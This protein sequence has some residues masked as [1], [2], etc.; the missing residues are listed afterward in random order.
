MLRIAVIS[1]LLANLLLLGFQGSKPAV[2]PETIAKHTVVEDPGIPTIHLYSEMVQDQDLMSGSRRC[3]SLGPFHSVEDKNETRALLEEVSANIS[4]RETRALVEK[5]YWVFMPPYE[6]LLKANQMLLSLQ[7]LGLK[8]VA[9][10]YNGDWT[11]AVSL[12]Y[13]LRQENAL[14][15]KEGLE[16]RGFAPKMRV[17]RQSESRYWLDVEQSPGSGLITM[18]MQDRPNDFMQ[19]SLPCPDQDPFEITAGASEILA[20]ETQQPQTQLPEEEIQPAV[21]ENIEPPTEETIEPQPEGNIEPPAEE[22]IEPQPD[23]ED[24][25]Q[26]EDGDGAQPTEEIDIDPEESIDTT[27][28]DNAKAAVPEPAIET[29]PE[30][31]SGAEPQ[32]TDEAELEVL[33]NPVDD[34]LQQQTEPSGEE[35]GSQ[36]IE[37]DGVD[38][39]ESIDSTPV[40][41]DEA[42]T[43]QIIL[44]EPE[45]DPEAELQNSN[46]AE[47]E[48]SENLVD[49]TLQQQVE[50][51]EEGDGL[52]AIEDDAINA[53]EIIESTPVD[54]EKAIPGPV[55]ETEP[56]NSVETGPAIETESENSVGTGPIIGFGIEPEDS[57]ENEAENIDEAGVE[58]SFGTESEGSD[59]TE[60]DDG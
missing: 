24:S 2:Q 22:I 23:E 50:I 19:R 60:T 28:V 48:A 21:E 25:S 39:E 14:R 40:D 7:A 43:D 36:P 35:D 4:E 12:G 59:G 58:G 56:A 49:D 26:Q 51:P 30:N 5:G 9:V 52:Q 27:P 45:N 32:N 6:S 3:F 47:P 8:D 11:N 57:D 31:G 33:E 55:I 15:R 18:D 17:Q 29:E 46:E 54:G 13:F 42:I 41:G 20:V 37:D 10:I 38:P 1:L 53:A 34:T 16:D 44:A